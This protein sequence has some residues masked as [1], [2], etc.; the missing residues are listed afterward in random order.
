MS[1]W[2]EVLLGECC[3][4]ISGSTPRRDHQEY[5]GGDIRWVTPKDL[6]GLEG[7]VLADTPEKITRAGYESCSTRLLPT[8]SVL[9]SSRAPIGLV[10]IT[11]REMCT[12]QGF[13]SLIPGPDVDASYLH[14]C[15]KRLA[16]RI[17][18]QSSGTTFTEI[19]RK[20]ME[21]V[22]IPLPP[23]PEQRRIAAILDKADAVRRKRQRTIDLADQFL[24]SAFLEMFGDPVTNPKGWPKVPLGEL[25]AIR[26]GASPRPIQ[27]FLGGTVPWIKIGDADPADDLYI[28]STAEHVTEEGASKSV[29]LQ[30]GSFVFANSGSLGFARILGIEG[31]IHD[32]WLSLE[33]L[34]PSLDRIF[35]LKQLNATTH[36]FLRI[37]PEGTQKN[38]NTSLMKKHRIILPPLDVQAQFSSLVQKTREVKTSSLAGVDGSQGL[39]DSLVQRAF[40]GELS[41]SSRGQ[42]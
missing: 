4:I 9:F 34:D 5:W 36:H 41:A 26:R 6:R 15:L 3:E 19:S 37:A 21:R 23:L 24:R 31:C 22:K 28:H 16:P 30:P 17:A 29:R 14:W 42:Q 2:P 12:N 32:G 7:P 39:F 35:L 10:A 11:G 38:L 1:S 20:G 13:K 27:S 18:A 8:G 40:R 33:N 25:C